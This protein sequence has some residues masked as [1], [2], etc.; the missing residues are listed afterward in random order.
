MSDFSI[1]FRNGL[2]FILKVEFAIGGHRRLWLEFNK[3]SVHLIACAL[4]L[5]SHEPKSAAIFFCRTQ[6][7]LPSYFNPPGANFLFSI[8]L[9]RKN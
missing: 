3:I 9:L 1:V 7:S 2:Y 8:M 6:S 5:R 4:G